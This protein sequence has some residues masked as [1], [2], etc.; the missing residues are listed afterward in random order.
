MHNNR[1]LPASQIPYV[2]HLSNVAMEILFAAQ[3]TP[4]FNT[5]LALQVAL[6]HD[7]IEDTA[8]TLLELE[9]QF[10]T[11]VA[12]GVLALTKNYLRNGYYLNSRIMKFLL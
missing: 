12:A 5:A 7:V 8:T 4:G 9:Q 2:V 10:G 3:H 6:L 1:T 11:E